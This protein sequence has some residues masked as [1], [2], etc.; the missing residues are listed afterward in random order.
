MSREVRHR[1][2]STFRPRLSCPSL[3]DLT[4][5]RICSGHSALYQIS[6]QSYSNGQ[7][8]VRTQGRN[9][10]ISEYWN[11]G[12]RR[13]QP[14]SPCFRPRPFDERRATADK[15]AGQG[16]LSVEVRGRKSEVGGQKSEDRGQTTEDRLRQSRRYPSFAYLQIAEKTK[17]FDSNRTF[18][19]L[20]SICV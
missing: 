16:E 12:K 3:R 5:F 8:K 18:L 17:S 9:G 15:M 7:E 13:I 19:T 11:S 20:S 6:E 14:P 2:L 4:F 1:A 10:G